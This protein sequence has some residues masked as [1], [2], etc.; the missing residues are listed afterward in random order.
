[1]VPSFVDHKAAG[2]CSQLLTLLSSGRSD[3]LRVTR[4]SISDADVGSTEE[5][6][7][8]KEGESFRFSQASNRVSVEE[9]SVEKDQLDSVRS[10]IRERIKA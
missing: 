4:T 10:F 1:M 9:A 7:L 3:K 5:I 2:G 8:G 6:L